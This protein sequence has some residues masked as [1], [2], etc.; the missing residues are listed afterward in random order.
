VLVH[1]IVN[2][3]ADIEGV[4]V[5]ERTKTGIKGFDVLVQ[6][7]FPKGSSLLLTGVTGAGKTIFALEFLCNGV[8]KFSE[9]G[10]YVTFEENKRSL[11]EQARQFG[12]NLPLLEEKGMLRIISIP[13]TDINNNTVSDILEIVK[14]GNVKRLIIDS[15][16]TLSL[17]LPSH[18]GNAIT[19]YSVS[20]FI[21][22]FI[23]RLSKDRR[24]TTLLISQA[25]DDKSLSQDNI[26][27]FSC[28]GVI[29][30]AF[31]SMGGEFSRS[32]IVRKMRRT[33]N[34]DDIH[35]LEIKDSGIVV[36]NLK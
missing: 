18:E 14:S 3:S 34:D 2:E 23:E 16:S 13:S 21:H 24:V 4:Q 28:D 29:H 33:K 36:H 35:P 11:I 17:Y 15:L 20:R 19:N 32:L 12:W 6:G 30:L 26:S 22:S 9:K 31:E 25:K 10:V 8:E 1:G 7:G 5:I 27:E